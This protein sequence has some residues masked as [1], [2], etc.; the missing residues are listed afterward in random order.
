MNKAWFVVSLLAFSVFLLGCGDDV[1]PPGM[2]MPEA[3]PA[4]ATL[5]PDADAASISPDARAM[6][7][8]VSPP[9]ATATE[10]LPTGVTT[11]SF[12]QVIEGETVTREVLLHVP[13][14][15]F[16][17]RADG[18]RSVTPGAG[19]EQSVDPRE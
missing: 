18:R 3:G 16:Q 7:A 5:T 15:E 9:D 6:D 17:R 1:A 13:F 10:A 11:L 14:E 8:M 4:D 19:I 2:T 12:D